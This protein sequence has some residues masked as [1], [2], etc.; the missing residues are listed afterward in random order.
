MHAGQ[1]ILKK[2]AEKKNEIQTRTR[3]QVAKKKRYETRRT[4]R[5]RT[6]AG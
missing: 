3:M 2:Y 4:K 5:V 6:V 1:E